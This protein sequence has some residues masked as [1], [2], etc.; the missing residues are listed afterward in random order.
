MKNLLFSLL[1]GMLAAFQ[2]AH[3]QVAIEIPLNTGQSLKAWHYSA[4]NTSQSQPVVIALHGCGGLYATLGQR[5]GLINARHHAMGQLLQHL[6]YH[7]L[8]PDSFGSRGVQ[9]ICSEVQ[10]LRNTVQIGLPERRADVLAALVWVR[11]QAWADRE[12]VAVL[13]WSHGAMTVLAAT[14][15]GVP[16]LAA[17]GA[18]FKTAIA[19]YPGCV[20]ADKRG[21]RPNTP[22]HIFMGGDDDWTLPAPCQKMVERLQAAGDDASFKLYPGAVHGFDDPNPGV[23]QRSDVP[24]RVRPGGVSYGAHP[25]ARQDALAQVQSILKTAFAIK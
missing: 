5:K 8:M 16:E 12:R 7:V 21:Y 10:R 9:G 15:V 11:Q 6:G 4:A 1:G 3:A 18:P 23:R 24:S 19:L 17:A 20:D 2:S 25:Q 13:G 14:E 22:L